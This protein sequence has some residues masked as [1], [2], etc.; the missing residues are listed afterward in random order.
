[1]A[2]DDKTISAIIT[3]CRSTNFTLLLIIISYITI[4]GTFHHRAKDFYRV[5]PSQSILHCYPHISF[6]AGSVNDGYTNPFI[7][8]YTH[9][10]LISVANTSGFQNTAIITAVTN[11]SSGCLRSS[12]RLNGELLMTPDPILEEVRTIREQLAAQFQFD[13]RKIIEDTQRRQ[14]LSNNKIVSFERPKIT[15]H[16]ADDNK[17]SPS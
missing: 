6:R 17:T 15:L 5:M 4:L 14:A 10:V 9:R 3:S 11:A 12:I 8:N 16:Q 2:S 13:I 7:R 1:M